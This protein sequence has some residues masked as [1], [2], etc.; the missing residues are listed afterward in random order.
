MIRKIISVINIDKNVSIFLS[1]RLFSYISYPLTLALIINFLNP[2]E[3]GYYYTFLTL[4]SFSMFLELGLGII[5]T[6]FA[7][8]EFAKLSWQNNLLIGDEIAVKRS[9]ALIKKTIIWFSIVAIAFFALMY[10]VGHYFFSNDNES[11][12]MNAWLVFIAIFSPGLIFSPIMSILQGFNKIKEV[13]SIIF[14][15]VVVSIIFFW[16]GLLLNLNI[17]ALILQFLVQNMISFSYLFF[18]YGRLIYLSFFQSSNVLSWRNEVLPLQLKTGFAWLVSYLGINLLIPF[19]FKIFGPEL[20]GQ[21]GMSFKIAEITSIICLAW[22][23]TRV[24]LMGK[25]ISKKNKK[26]FFNLFKSTLR[27]IVLTGFLSLTGIIIIFKSLETIAYSQFLDRVLTLNLVLTLSFGYY[28]F[29]ISNFLSM[30]IRAFKDE[31]MMYPNVIVLLVYSLAIY[32]SYN[33][34]SYISLVISFLF[35]NVFILLPFSIR[36]SLVVLKNKKWN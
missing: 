15:Q 1:G 11:S 27:S 3:Q 17:Y 25:L 6:N 14:L 23:N 2:V 31:K 29:S 10:F 16:I 13:Q 5:L 33:Y 8:H 34:L 9:L 19:S 36:F 21:L 22:T 32:Y 28:M 24:P 18:K 20:A 4:L 12:Y 26:E 30:T 7:S 35:V